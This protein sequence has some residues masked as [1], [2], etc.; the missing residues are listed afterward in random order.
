MLSHDRNHT[1]DFFQDRGGYWSSANGV[2]GW[3]APVTAYTTSVVWADGSTRALNARQRP[4]LFFDDPEESGG[5][6][7]RRATPQRVTTC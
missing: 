5:S 2:D 1:T 4:F 7:A 3:S 6:G